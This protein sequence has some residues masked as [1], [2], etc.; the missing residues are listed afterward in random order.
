MRSADALVGWPGGAPAA[1][2]GRGQ[3]ARFSYF[4]PANATAAT[5]SPESRS[6]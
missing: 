3:I 5:L 4:P 6:M 2:N 1:V